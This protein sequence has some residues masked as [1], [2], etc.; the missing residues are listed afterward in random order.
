MGTSNLSVAQVAEILGV[1]SRTIQRE[2]NRGRLPATKVGKKF[3]ISKHDLEQYTGKLSSSALEQFI[4]QNK[5]SMVT[6]L[7]KLVSIPSQSEDTGNEKQLAVEIHSFLKN[8][9]IRTVIHGRGEEITLRA[10]YGYADTGILLNCPLD[11]TP[12]GDPTKWKHPPFDGI[13]KRGKMYGRGTADSKAGMVCMI[14]T[15]LALKRFIPEDLIRVEL[16]FDGGEHSGAY[17]GMKATVA[18]GLD[19]ACGIIGYASDQK[20]IQIG[21]RGYHRYALTTKGRASHTGSRTRFGINAIEKMTKIINE[22]LQNPFP[23]YS[24]DLF[25]F[26]SRFTVAQIRGGHAINIVPDECSA[27][28]DVRTLP[29]QTK[30]TVDNYLEQVIQK[31]QK[32]DAAIDA[33]FTYL[34]GEEGYALDKN[35]KIIGI[36]EKIIKKRYRKKLPLAVSGPSHIGALLY[37]HGIPVVIWGPKGGNVHNYDEYVTID[38]LPQTVVVYFEV[39]RQ[40]FES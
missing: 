2:V 11:T 30:K 40:Y 9:G 8:S 32:Q 16:V 29:K 39:I 36:L 1:S 24:D 7:Q 38:S 34:L 27:Q 21:A 6:L 35:E 15:L 23:T 3:M 28:V 12:V 33:D 14:Y 18:R 10:T 17:H 4:S 25:F 22:A 37:K 31:A 13:I 5:Q 20:D 19:V 26:G